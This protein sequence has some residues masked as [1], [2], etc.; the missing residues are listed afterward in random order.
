MLA[1]RIGGRKR[2]EVI[3]LVGSEVDRKGQR[4]KSKKEK[5]KREREKEGKMKKL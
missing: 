3:K 5:G 1:L 4:G 2:W